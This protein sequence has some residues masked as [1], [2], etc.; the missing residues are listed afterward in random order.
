MTESYCN[1]SDT[2]TFLK[3]TLVSDLSI[4][5]IKMFSFSEMPFKKIPQYWLE[6]NKTQI[7][8]FLLL[9]KIA[10]DVN[11][12]FKITSPGPRVITI[13]FNLSF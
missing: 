11:F 10:S 13:K 4:I 2:H 12:Y 9:L 3:N 6:L 8:S 1:Y 5:T 7:S